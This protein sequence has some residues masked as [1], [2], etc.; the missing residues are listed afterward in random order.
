MIKPCCHEYVAS[1]RLIVASLT[2]LNN[3]IVS[4]IHKSSNSLNLL[5]TLRIILLSF[6]TNDSRDIVTAT[7]PYSACNDFDFW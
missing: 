7:K 5:L 2:W 1:I 4:Y 3:N 6:S